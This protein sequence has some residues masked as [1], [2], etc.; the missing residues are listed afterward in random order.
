MLFHENLEEIIFNRH[1]I[2][3]VDGLVVLSGY[4]G[5][6]PAKRLGELP[7]NTKLIYGMYG[8]DGIDT[9]L[10]SSLLEIHNELENV[11]ILYSTTPVHSKC[12]IWKHGNEIV[13]ALVGSANFS[14]NGLCTP[15]REVLAETSHD[16]FL[17]LNNYI[18]KIIDN[19]I[20]CDT[21]TARGQR[22][23]EHADVQAVSSSLVSNVCQLVLTDGGQNV[24]LRSGLNWAHANAH[25]SPNDA[26]IPIRKLNI[27]Q[28]PH[29]FPPKQ[30]SPRFPTGRSQRNNDFIEIIWDDG[31]IMKGLLEGTQNIDGIKYPKQIS[32]SPSKSI[33]GKYIRKRL[34]VPSNGI[35]DIRHLRR[36][37]RATID[38]KLMNEGVYYFDFSV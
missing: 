6:N 5:P 26:N 38:V 31:T 25:V 2:F 35:I 19:S 12:Y 14:T 32:S 17:P 30:V 27:L 7:F 18:D 13:H 21:A 10:H 15:F 3:S 20:T 11:E 9:K 4:V 33:L 23:R 22:I 34:R 8:S 28:Y 24:P 1:E 36:Y 37:G 16:T 29:L